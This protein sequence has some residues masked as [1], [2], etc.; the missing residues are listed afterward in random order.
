MNNLKE[1]MDRLYWAAVRMEM[2]K[3]KS[4]YCEIQPDDFKEIQS[5]IQWTLDTIRKMVNR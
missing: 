5:E 2:L 3:E 1:V 4:G